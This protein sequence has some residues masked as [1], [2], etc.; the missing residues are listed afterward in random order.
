MAITLHTVTDEAIPEQTDL[1]VGRYRDEFQ[2]MVDKDVATLKHK[3]ATAGW[4]DPDPKKL[5]QRY[6][7]GPD[8]A[9]SL[10]AV[11]RRA[12]T[13]HKVDPEFYKNAKTE[14]GHVAIKF[15]VTRKVDKDGKP[16][17]DDTLTA[18]GKPTPP[19]APPKAS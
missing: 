1:E 19:A 16:V 8:D 12:G 5:F 14:A 9:G 6:V 7:V 10:K 2:Q 18:D 15:H 17:A 11:I 13:L 4:P 3:T